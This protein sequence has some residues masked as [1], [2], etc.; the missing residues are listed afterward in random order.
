VSQSPSK[1]LIAILAALACVSALVP[2][3]LVSAAGKSN[4]DAKACVDD[5]DFGTDPEQGEDDCS[6][7]TN[8]LD[9]V[10][11][12]VVSPDGKFVYA[13][14]EDDDAVTI[15]KRDKSSGKLKPKGCVD[16][17][18]TGTNPS[19][20]EDA[21]AQSAD[22]LAGASAMV[23]SDDGKS[24]YVVGEIDDAV[25]RFDRNKSTGALN[26]VGC[27]DDND[28]GTDPNQGEDACAQSTNGLAGVSAIAISADDKNLYTASEGDDAITRFNRGNDGSITPQ[29]CIDD[30]DTGTEPDQGEDTCAQSTDG[31]AGATGVAVSPDGKS[32][33]ATSEFDEAV[34]RFERN[35]SNG[36]I[37]PQDC[38]EDN[39]NAPDACAD[40]TKGL[41]S[42]E[43]M[44]V[45]PNG[46]S[47]YVVA[48]VSNSVVRFD[49]NKNTGALKPKG[50]IEDKQDG[51]D[52]CGD[53]AHGLSEPGGLAISADGKRLYISAGGDD[54]LTALKRSS[55][56]GAL[57]VLG[58][59]DDNDNGSGEG[60]CDAK[61]DGLAEPEGVAVSPDGKHIYV[62][63]EGD[64]AV[65][66]VAG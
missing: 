2:M 49:R 34:V 9:G 45:S 18:D 33:Y 65:V 53:K 43:S 23:I 10:R 22:G 60:K 39:D 32:L 28:T 24:L 4:L 6:K 29:T 14:S 40:A 7:E 30:N 12:I 3:A 15:F 46:D 64:D 38:I 19:Q 5:N 52:G 50:C 62:A 61:G 51:A 63:A 57:K 25:V 17:N 20:G 11:G 1:P 66:L 21:C 13:S 56:S 37:G 42:T 58:C 59:V 44:V 27:V 16:D 54:A 31:L 36:T 48:E 41:E 35:K 55:K 47:L 8:G 26:P